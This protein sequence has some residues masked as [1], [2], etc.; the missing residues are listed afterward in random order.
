MGR[1]QINTIIELGS[2]LGSSTALMARYLP[3]GGKIYAVDTFD[4]ANENIVEDST[5]G[6][7]ATKE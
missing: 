2:W 4:I 1:Y 3:E 5:A 6:I 7:K